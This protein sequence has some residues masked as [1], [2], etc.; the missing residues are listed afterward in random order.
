MKKLVISLQLV[1]LIFFV[2]WLCACANILPPSGGPRDSIPPVLVDATPPDSTK[3]FKG[4]KIVLTFDEFVQ[5]DKPHESVVYSPLLKHTVAPEAHL[6][7][8]TIRIKD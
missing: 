6:R 5:L 8:V 7:T 2:E 1:L 4:G 3:Q